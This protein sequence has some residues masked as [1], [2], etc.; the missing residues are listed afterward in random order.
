MTNNLQ[1]ELSVAIRENQIVPYFQP[2]VDLR[3]G[4][5]LGFEV[6]AR[7]LT[8]RQGEVPPETF[9]QLAEESGLIGVL[10]ERLLTQ[11]CAAAAAWPSHLGLSFNVSPL[12][13]GDERLF[14]QIRSVSEGM[15]FPLS[16]L[17]IE[18]TE[19]AVARDMDAARATLK[20]LKAAGACVALDDFGK[21]YSSF[22][23]LQDLPFDRLKID[24]SFIRSM[25]SM[26]ENRK[27]VA[28]II[29]L[30]H[31]LSFSTVAEG[32]ETQRQ[33]DMLVALGCDIGQ[34]WLFGRPVP[35]ES[36]PALIANHKPY[37][38]PL[39]DDEVAAE[40]SLSA[41]ALPTLRLAQLQAIYNGAPVALCFLDTQLRYI[42]LN[43]RWAEFNGYPIAAHI[44]R[45]VAEMVPNIFVQS[46][47]LLRRA[48]AG[49]A[50]PDTEFRRPSPHDP[51]QEIVVLVSYQ[52]AYDEAGEVVGV[53]IS[54]IDITARKLAEQALRESEEHYRCMVELS[55]QIPWTAG[56]D[57]SVE[58]ISSRWTT[59][60]GY[61]VAETVGHGWAKAIHP[62][63]LPAT[64]LQWSK[65]LQTGEPVDVE[66]RLRLADGSSL[67]VQARGAP[68]R[69]PQ[70][71]IL[72][73]Y[74]LVEN[75]HER[76]SSQ[77][78]LRALKARTAS[79][80]G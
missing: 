63:D 5:L 21:G 76:K 80:S 47:T 60:T 49:A 13:L 41:E 27:I 53:S 57:G 66:Y 44:G 11:A 15:H 61:S 35:A 14:E 72:K 26:R 39:A 18:V 25:T 71:E 69:G 79:E 78:A 33:A 38:A 12:Q 64:E 74:G 1:K 59:L 2:L 9:I 4:R 43:R 24:E 67:W 51:D 37:P 32:V 23:R 48:L 16:R 56:P 45:T 3:R 54:M 31:S 75:I 68:R 52:P 62:D 77:E 8:S 29:G 40:I 22:R 10:S 19:S 7:W 28:S 46:E 6:L 34:G 36:V 30:G 58:E 17:T 70:G 20:A 55:P 73:W 50:V 65:C 42:S